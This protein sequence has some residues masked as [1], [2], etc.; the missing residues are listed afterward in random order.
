M[1]M[2]RQFT[3]LRACSPY[4]Q[5]TWAQILPLSKGSRDTDNP[6]KYID[7]IQRLPVGSDS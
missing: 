2:G 4:F 6:S 5:S 3:H 1:R 7:N